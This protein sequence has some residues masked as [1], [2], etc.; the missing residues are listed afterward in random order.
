[1]EETQTGMAIGMALAGYMPVSCYPRFDF[2]ILAANQLVNYLDKID[3]LTNNNFDSKIIIRTIVGSTYPLNG[4]AA[5]SRPYNCIER[6]NEIFRSHQTKN[7]IK[8]FKYK[9]AISKK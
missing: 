5:H 4:T 3:Y 2:L 7:K 1:M 8:F 6:I 9:N